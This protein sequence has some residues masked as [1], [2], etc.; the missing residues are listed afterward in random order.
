VYLNFIRHFSQLDV[1][2][3]IM[4]IK[5]K[6]LVILII[7]IVVV[8]GLYMSLSYLNVEKGIETP[9][10]TDENSREENV[11]KAPNITITKYKGVWMR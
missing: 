4:A 6:I 8:S 11:V 1:V 2:R 3:A 5:T 9:S 7:G 10:R